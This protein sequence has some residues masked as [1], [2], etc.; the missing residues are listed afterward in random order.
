MVL[1]CVALSEGSLVLKRDLIQ[2]IDGEAIKP[3]ISVVV[4]ASDF[5]AENG[6]LMGNNRG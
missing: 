2:F 5:L 1:L 3:L 4:C 6:F